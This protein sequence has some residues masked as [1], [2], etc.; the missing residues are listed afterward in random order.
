M[1]PARSSGT[2]AD[3][4]V[5]GSSQACSA[6]RGRPPSDRPAPPQGVVHRD[7]KPSNIMVGAFG[8]VQVMD[9]GV[10][11]VLNEKVGCVAHPMLETKQDLCVVRTL[12]RGAR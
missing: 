7:L 11:K 1:R 3:A 2:S 8:E 9:W 6:L 4:S 5:V 12:R 10:A